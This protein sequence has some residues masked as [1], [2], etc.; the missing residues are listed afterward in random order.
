MI[1]AGRLRLL[2]GARPASR[3]FLRCIASTT[4]RGGKDAIP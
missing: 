1:G 3:L 4:G 2:S